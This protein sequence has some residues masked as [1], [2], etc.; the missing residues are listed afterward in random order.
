MP[1]QI[2]VW[3]ISNLDAKNITL[4]TVS[5]L[6]SFSSVNIMTVQELSIELDCHE[7]H[8][9]SFEEKLRERKKSLEE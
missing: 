6:G 2:K 7:A 8:A 3:D 5:I 9:T 1:T 4:E